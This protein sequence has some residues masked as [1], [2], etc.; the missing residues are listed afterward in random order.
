MA[1]ELGKL[2]LSLLDSLTLPAAMSTG[3]GDAP[4]KTVNSIEEFAKTDD[5]PITDSGDTD[6]VDTDTDIEGDEFIQDEPLENVEDSPIKVWAQFA[7]ERGLIDLEDGEDIGDSE[8]FLIE[9]FNKKVENVFKEYKKSLPET[10]Q[11]LI[12]AHEKGLSIE[13]LLESEARIMEYSSIDTDKLKENTELQ[14]NILREFLKSQDFEDDEIERKIEKYEDNMLLEDES[15]SALKKLIKYEEKYKAQALKEAEENTKKQKVEYEKRLKEYSDTVMGMEEIIPGIPTTKEQ[16]EAIVKLTT[17]PVAVLKNGMPISALK[18]MEMEDP[19]FMT[20]IAYI[21]GVLNWDLSSIE[22]K[23]T[24]K[25][26]RQVRK[27]VDTYAEGGKSPLSKL[28]LKTIR[29]AI[30]ISNNQLFK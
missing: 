14:K 3:G 17:K 20:K 28:D 23:A 5:A 26:S 30:K 25:A 10:L 19:N 29:K 12:D 24:T 7:A 9:K 18:K 1:E 13:D 22:R 15:A 2:D 21:A 6:G 27:D 11:E 16:R 8:D 4:I